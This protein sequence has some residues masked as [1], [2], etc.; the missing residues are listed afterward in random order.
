MVNK[1]VI[2]KNIIKRTAHWTI[3]PG[4]QSVIMQIVR[5]IRG[6]IRITP[7]LQALFAQ[8]AKFHNI[9]KG[10]RCFILATGPSINKQDL[11]PLNNEI[12]IAISNFYKHKNIKE[13][14]PLYHVEAARHY[15]FDFENLKESFEGFDKFYSDYT[16]YFFGHTSYDYSIFNFLMQNPQFKKENM[17]F[18]NYNYVIPLDEDNYNHEKVWDICKPLFG[19]RSAVCCAIQLAVYMGFKDIFLLGCDHDF[20]T[21]TNRKRYNYFYDYEET[22][23]QVDPAGWPSSK[24]EW[25]LIYH[26]KWKEYNLMQKYLKS[27]GQTIYNATEGGQLDV[28]PLVTLEEALSGNYEKWKY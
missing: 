21:Y 28:F 3:P 11:R 20:I 22:E 18:L 14:N 26:K 15:P 19:A 25:F 8:N 27:K 5:N 16:I 4:F 12:C 7:E 2:L 1:T 23:G 24:E 17:Y 13:I 10:Q 6:R 9:H